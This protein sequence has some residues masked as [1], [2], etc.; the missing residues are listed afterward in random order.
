MDLLRY[1]SDAARAN[2][3]DWHAIFKEIAGV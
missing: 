2:H 1:P 3:D